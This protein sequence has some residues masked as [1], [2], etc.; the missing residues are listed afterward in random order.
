M[1]TKIRQVLSS[2]SI[3]GTTVQNMGREDLGEIKDLMIDLSG[4]RI[5]YAVLSF[6]GFLGMGDKLFAIPWEAFQVVQEEEV[7]LLNVAKEKLEQAPGFDKDNWPDMAD[8]T[9]GKSIHT[10]Y[11]YDPYWD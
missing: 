6:G 2:S 1:T 5:A 3:V 10:Y 8:M 4:G 9:W 11:G 7:L